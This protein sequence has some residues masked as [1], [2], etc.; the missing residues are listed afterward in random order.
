MRRFAHGDDLRA[1]NRA[2]ETPE[3]VEAVA[4][5]GGIESNRVLTQPRPDGVVVAARLREQ[6]G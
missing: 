2:S 4:W 5:N 3:V 6:D 1:A